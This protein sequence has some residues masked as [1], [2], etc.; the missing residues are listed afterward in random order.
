MWVQTFCLECGRS[1]QVNADPGSGV[2]VAPC[3]F[4][5][6]AAFLLW[7]RA[8]REGGETVTHS[9]DS[10]HGLVFDASGYR[11]MT[12]DEWK[13]TDSQLTPTDDGGTKEKPQT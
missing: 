11:E 10:R 1:D 13:A 8:L 12:E 4:C 5:G 7:S 6:H 2:T 9:G 3:E